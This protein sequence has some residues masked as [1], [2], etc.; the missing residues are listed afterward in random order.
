MRVLHYGCWNDVGHYL[1]ESRYLYGDRKD[2][3]WDNIDGGLC[4]DKI[5]GQIQGDAILHHRDGW[6][7]ISFWDRSVDSRGGSN[8]N[9]FAEGNHSFEE[10][11]QIA[12]DKFP[13]IM[14]RF[15]FEIVE[16]KGQG[17]Q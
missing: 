14:S 6:T 9:F 15:K 1:R 7:A 3:P 11:V 2:L 12:K 4:P 10:M 17:D 8:S 16:F 5:N 13:N